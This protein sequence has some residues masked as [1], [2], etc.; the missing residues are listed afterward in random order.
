MLARESATTRTPKATWPLSAGTNG[1]IAA[2]SFAITVIWCVVVSTNTLS[3][4]SGSTWPGSAYTPSALSERSES[5]HDPRPPNVVVES[6]PSGR[7]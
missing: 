1:A 4:R 3:P 5:V 7:R 2:S 6:M